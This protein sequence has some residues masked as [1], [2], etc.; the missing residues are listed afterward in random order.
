MTWLSLSRVSR[1]SIGGAYT[2]RREKVRLISARLAT[3]SRAKAVRGK[4]MKRE[5]DFSKGRRGA[6]IPDA[7][8][9]TRITIRLDDATLEWFRAEAHRMKGASYQNLI[10][11]ALRAHIHAT[12]EPLERTLR[13]V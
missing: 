9:K 2:W 3:A 10:N 11:E 4:Q 13:R 12:R 7:K 8:G 5:Y 6:V 1:H